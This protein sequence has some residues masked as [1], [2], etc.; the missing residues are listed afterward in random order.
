MNELKKRIIISIIAIPFIC[1]I[2]YLG[3]P[4]LEGLLIILLVGMLW[5]WFSLN[6]KNS[7]FFKSTLKHLVI[8]ICGTLYIFFAIV[9]LCQIAHDPF[10]ILELLIIVWST[11]VGAYFVGSLL[12]GPRI[13]PSISPKKTW[14]GFIG[15][16]LTA[17]LTTWIPRGY[18]GIMDKFH[19]FPLIIIVTL[20]IAAQIGDL[21]E[22][23]A[24]R[25]FK[26]KD[27]SQII[28]GHGGLLDRFD[29]LLLVS[30]IYKLIVV[31]LK[32]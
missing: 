12:K 20:S 4:Y 16:I 32:I 24:K 31:I 25:Y 22:S 8:F 29:S 23:S 14:S 26:V 6:T 1:L 28:P 7:R 15:G 3:S 13:A 2:L 21:I 10:F 27:T 19:F 18:P 11:D 17:I 30:W 5:E 9:F